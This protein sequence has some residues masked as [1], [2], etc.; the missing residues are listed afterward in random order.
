MLE[1]NL[2]RKSRERLEFLEQYLQRGMLILEIG[3]AEG[4]L[5][6]VIRRNFDVAYYG[7]EPSLDAKIAISR[8]DEVW[9]SINKVPPNLQFDIIIAFHV[10]EHIHNIG[11]MMSKL[12][13]LLSSNGIII[14]ETPNYFGNTRL[15]WDFNKEHIH[16]FSPASISCLLEKRGVGVRELS[17]GHYESAIYDDS[18]RV[19]GSKKKG[20]KELKHNFVDRLQ[21]LLG[22]RYIIYGIGGDFEALVL[23]YVKASSVIAIIDS[24]KDKVGKRV[25]GKTV[26]G[27][28]VIDDY[29]T[30]IFFIATYR[31]QNQIIQ[32]L[33]EKGICRSHI[34]TLQD[35]LEN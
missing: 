14:F 22:D 16:L 33:N 11:N 17:T 10:F 28:G 25:I 20:E 1:E 6:E 34:I 21:R 15:P 8:L 5:G 27:P 26:Q 32:V 18:M 2:G 7:I 12:C 31:Y 24:S 35:I 4:A 13:K 29:L 30:E 23:P 19:V 9:V 3:C